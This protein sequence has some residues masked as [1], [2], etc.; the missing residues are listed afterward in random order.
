MAYMS[1]ERKQQLEKIKAVLKKKHPRAEKISKCKIYP[2]VWDVLESDGFE[3]SNHT[4]EVVENRL[5]YLG[6]VTTEI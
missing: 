3:E 6:V 2:N 5:V 1:Q 4:Y